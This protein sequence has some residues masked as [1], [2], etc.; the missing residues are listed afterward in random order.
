MSTS[1]A[2]SRVSDAVAMTLQGGTSASDIYE[3]CQAVE[4]QAPRWSN[5]VGPYRVTRSVASERVFRG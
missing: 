2:H 4:S 5:K 1:L 3:T